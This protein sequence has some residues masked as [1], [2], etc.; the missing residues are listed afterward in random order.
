MS[1]RA[2]LKMV[3]LSRRVRTPS[4]REDEETRG[5]HIAAHARLA[6]PPHHYYFHTYA[7]SN[8]ELR[9]GGGDD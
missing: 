3:E 1:D 8:F 4:L 9:R 6:T 2:K 5:L 7:A